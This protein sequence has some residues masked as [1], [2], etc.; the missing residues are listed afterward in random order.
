MLRF[1]EL[2]DKLS[3][4]CYEKNNPVL[5]S[6]QFSFADDI[7]AMFVKRIKVQVLQLQASNCFMFLFCFY[8]ESKTT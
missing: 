4:V 2:P 8:C 3:A 6:K 5:V 1:I 7:L